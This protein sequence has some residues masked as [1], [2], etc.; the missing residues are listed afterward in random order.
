MGDRIRASRKS[1][2]GGPKMIERKKK[3]KKMMMRSSG[4]G[5]GGRKS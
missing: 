3:K 1:D 5:E 4:E 2:E